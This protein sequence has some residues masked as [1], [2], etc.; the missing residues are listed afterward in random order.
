MPS[1]KRQVGIEREKELNICFLIITSARKHRK[2]INNH[3]HIFFT[4]KKVAHKEGWEAAL[5]T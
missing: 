4:K 2:S 5:C 1:E 3:R